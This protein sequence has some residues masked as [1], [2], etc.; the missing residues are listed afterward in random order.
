MLQHKSNLKFEAVRIKTVL[1]LAARQLTIETAN[2]AKLIILRIVA[3]SLTR[4]F[5]F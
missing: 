5:N 2:L 1:A 3:W 4:E